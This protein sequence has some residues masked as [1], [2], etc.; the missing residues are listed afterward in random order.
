MINQWIT[1]QPESWYTSHFLLV[2]ILR[3]RVLVN[4]R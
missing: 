4:W 1:E 3:K 2:F